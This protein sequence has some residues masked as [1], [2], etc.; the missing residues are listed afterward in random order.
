ML[1]I[2]KTLSPE[3]VE[4]II[5]LSDKDRETDD[6]VLQAT[7]ENYDMGITPLDALRAMLAAQNLPKRNLCELLHTLSKEQIIE[8]TAMMWLGRGDSPEIWGKPIGEAFALL[9]D[10]ARAKSDLHDIDYLMGKPLKAYLE[11]AMRIEAD[12]IVPG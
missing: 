10:E 1:E 2:T 12:G 5:L 3:L 7:A 6:A 8:L 9:C 11:A 4:E